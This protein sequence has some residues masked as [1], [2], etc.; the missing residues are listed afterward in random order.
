MEEKKCADKPLVS[1]VTMQVKKDEA[2]QW[3][4]PT[5]EDVSTRVMAQPYIRFT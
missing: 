1:G 5:L 4:K 3:E 2:N